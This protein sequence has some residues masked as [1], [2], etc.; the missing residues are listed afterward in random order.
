MRNGIQRNSRGWVLGL[1]LVTVLIL[2]LGSLTFNQKQDAEEKEIPV[3]TESYDL[4]EV[5]L[6]SG[7]N[8]LLAPLQ[9]YYPEQLLTPTTIASA[10][11]QAVPK[12]S[13]KVAYYS[14]KM[15]IQVPKESQQVYQIQFTTQYKHAM[16]VFVNGQLGGEI[17][18][19]GATKVATTP[20]ANFLS[21]LATGVDGKIE[22]LFQGAQFYHARIASNLP[23]VQI[24]K[25]SKIMAKNYWGRDYL[26][27]G[28][29]LSGACLMLCLYWI[30]S[31][32]REI[33]YF[34]CSCFAIALRQFEQSRIWID[35]RP[36]A[37]GL[38]FPLEY[39]S[40]ALL[41][42]CLTLYLGELLK[43]PFWHKIKCLVLGSSFVYGFLTVFADSHI[44]TQVL[45]L[46]QGIL[47]F[48]IPLA[49]GGLFFGL[50]NPDQRQLVQLFGITVY[51]LA[52]IEDILLS[53]V[54]LVMW[55]KYYSINEVGMALFLFSQIFA[56]F[57]HNNQLVT[58]ATKRAQHLQLE[59]Q[60]LEELNR[61]KTEFLGNIS[62][63]LKTPVTVLTNYTHN[64]QIGLQQLEAGRMK[65]TLQHNAAALALTIN[66]LTIFLQQML[67]ATAI[68]E[69]RMQLFPCP[70][71]LG[72]LIRKTARTHFSNL[73]TQHNQLIID[74]DPELPKIVADSQALEQ[75][76]TNLLVNALRHT[77]NGTITISA[78]L[79]KNEAKSTTDDTHKLVQQMV[80]IKVADTGSGIDPKR[81]PGLFERYNHDKKASSS[82]SGTGLGMYICRHLVEQHGGQI[83]VTSQLG[84]G[85]TVWFTLPN[86]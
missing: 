64:L 37:S 83:A 1:A 27:I 66:R 82:E 5:P 19:P 54:G 25:T 72:A 58:L 12:T 13:L 77:E 75:I 84:A 9:W 29:F 2:S 59:K 85:T 79:Q 14:Q 24:L 21:V 15:V 18:V 8:V 28:I 44:Y 43:G 78:N 45:T 86:A 33:L 62:H 22:L 68:D 3:V 31:K 39:F 47:I 69:G 23:Q 34:G 60:S 65:T 55:T 81:L 35:T 40:L 7:Q 70:L 30:G 57:I 53:R 36:Q 48:T 51:F 46:Y 61:M 73:N 32:A 10:R 71:D 38:I 20:G 49:I 26:M 50:K 6:K 4:R 42:V 16:K 74:C 80:V 52:A 67:S 76:L 56:L 11:R 63:E 41:T 17:G